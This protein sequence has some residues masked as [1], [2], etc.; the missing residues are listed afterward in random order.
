MNE[1]DL[2]QFSDVDL[3]WVPSQL[4]LALASVLASLLL[5][6]AAFGFTDQN[7]DLQ[8]QARNRQE[9]AAQSGVAR[10]AKATTA[11]AA[12]TVLAQASVPALHG[13][14]DGA[15][16][17]RMRPNWR[18]CPSSSS[19]E[20]QGRMGEFCRSSGGW[21][22]SDSDQPPQPTRGSSGRL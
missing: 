3:P 15:R 13:T 6:S 1:P 16:D 7:A 19:T 9:Q 17:Q 22:G 8:M 10:A 14:K 5:A 21:S 11:T 2:N 12:T 18:N 4:L 20:D